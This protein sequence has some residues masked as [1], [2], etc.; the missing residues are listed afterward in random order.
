MPD[1]HGNDVPYP[2]D[3]D[4]ELGA[5]LPHVAGRKITSSIAVT[6]ISVMNWRVIAMA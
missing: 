1:L 4:E 3:H 6:P 5:Y 2:L